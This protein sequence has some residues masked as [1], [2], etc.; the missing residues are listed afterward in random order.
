MFYN[1]I[2][3]ELKKQAGEVILFHSATGKDSICLLDI[4]SQN[5]TRVY[6]VFMYIVQGLDYENAYINWAL[7]KYPNTTFYQT[8]HFCLYSFIKNGYLGIKKNEKIETM[9]IH[10]IDALVR[11][12]SKIN[13]SVY[14][15]KKSDGVTRRLM[16][17]QCEN[18]IYKTTNKAYP[19][20]DMKNHDVLNYI[21]D[22]SLIQPFCYSKNKPSSGCDISDPIFL[23]YMRAKYPN[24][25]QK[26]FK[27]FPFCEANLFKYDTYGKSKAD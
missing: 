17:N 13:W 14:G 7:K 20:M 8:S 26:I 9:S 18:G 11:V 4:L 16:L 3:D 15:F 25:L 24:D 5:F 19:L 21:S 10:K 2:I 1:R 23:A 12:K 22:N 27:V 6:C